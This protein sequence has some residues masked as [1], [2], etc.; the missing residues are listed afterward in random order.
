MAKYYSFPT[1][2]VWKQISSPFLPPIVPCS[3]KRERREVGRKDEGLKDRKRVRDEGREGGV[4][5]KQSDISAVTGTLHMVQNIPAVQFFPLV[6]YLSLIY[7]ESLS[8]LMEDHC[9]CLS[10]ACPFFNHIAV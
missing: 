10:F 9:S 1:R 3:I 6:S 4:E 8:V 7:T 2:S 5:G